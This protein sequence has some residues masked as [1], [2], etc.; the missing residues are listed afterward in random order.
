MARL[1]KPTM[2]LLGGVFAAALLYGV[3]EAN[4]YRLE[5]KLNA[6]QA[7]CAAGNKSRADSYGK[8][9]DNKKTQPDSPKDARPEIAKR[10]GAPVA[11]SAK[12]PTDMPKEDSLDQWLDA[13]RDARRQT[14]AHPKEQELEDAQVEWLVA[15][16]DRRTSCDPAVLSTFSNRDAPLQGVQAQIAET[17]SAVSESRSWPKVAAG[18]LLFIGTLP[19]SWY[20]F[21]RRVRELGNAIMGR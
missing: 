9:I 19:F 4:T 5:S 6:L 12:H 16:Y 11:S 7:E 1:E 18:A 15:E 13:A 20:F 8:F 3:G 2:I 14:L 17:Q 21:L 10:G